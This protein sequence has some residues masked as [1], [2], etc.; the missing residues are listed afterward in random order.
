MHRGPL[1]L[2]LLSN[3]EGTRERSVGGALSLCVL[4]RLHGNPSLSKLLFALCGLRVRLTGRRGEQGEGFR[5]LQS[6]E[7]QNPANTQKATS[8]LR[9]YFKENVPREVIS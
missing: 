1:L 7:F 4:S 6:A 9:R 8:N 3:C 2:C 5:W